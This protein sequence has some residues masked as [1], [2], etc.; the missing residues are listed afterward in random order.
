MRIL[1]LTHRLPYAPNRGDRLRAYHMLQHLREHADVELVS[2]VHDDE[3][4]SHVGRE[5]SSSAG[6]R[7]CPL[8][9]RTSLHVSSYICDTA[10]SSYN[11]LT[12]RAAASAPSPDLAPP[13]RTPYRGP[14]RPI[15]RHLRLLRPA[16]L[17]A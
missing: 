10:R 6:P 5:P 15:G 16:A 8:R 12:F 7:A 4:A 17:R 11:V 3:E 13:P 2:L 14:P 1:A 9:S